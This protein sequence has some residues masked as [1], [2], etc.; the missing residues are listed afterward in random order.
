LG[1]WQSLGFDRQSLI[2]DRQ[3]VD[4]AQHDYRFKPAS[5]ALTLAFEPIDLSTA[6]PR[7]RAAR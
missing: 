2:A 7:Q 5:P 4:A 3:F 1:F 6:G